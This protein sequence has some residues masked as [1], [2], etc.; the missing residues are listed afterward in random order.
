MRRWRGRGRRGRGGR[1]RGEGEILDQMAWDEKDGVGVN[2]WVDEQGTWMG[3]QREVFQLSTL[4]MQ[5]RWDGKRWEQ[6]VSILGFC[7]K[8]PHLQQ[9]E[10]IVSVPQFR[11]QIF[12][13]HS[14]LVAPRDRHTSR[15]EETRKVQFSLVRMTIT[16]DITA[17]PFKSK[18]VTHYHFTIIVCPTV[19]VV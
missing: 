15:C 4:W 1:P 19:S 3:E 13:I 10:G 6:R 12:A 5:E 2:G 16:S 11:Y 14:Y 17:F 8:E 7:G 9:G 18:L